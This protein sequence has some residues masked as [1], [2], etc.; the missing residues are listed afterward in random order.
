MSLFRSLPPGFV[1]ALALTACSVGGDPPP[2][3]GST[4]VDAGCVGGVTYCGRGEVVQRCEGGRRVDVETCTGDRVCAEGLGCVAC[5]P[6]YHECQGDSLYVCN[7][8]GSAFTLVQTCT[9]DEL[10]TSGGLGGA[11]MNACDAAVANRSNIGCEYWA[12]DLDNEHVEGLGAPTI[13]WSEQF[14]V[15]IANPS[16]VT[17]TVRV[18]VN[19]GAVGGAIA[20]REVFSG[21]VA[22]RD[23]LQIDLDQREVDGELSDAPDDR[24]TWVSSHAYRIQSNYPV[25]AYQFNPIIQSFSNDA[26]LLLP[27]SGLDSH[28]RVLGYPTS[29]PVDIGGP[30]GNI[31]GIPDHSFVTIIGTEPNTMVRVTAGGPIIGDTKGLGIG[32]AAAGEV[33]ERVIGRYDV[34]NL[35]SDGMTGDLTG[36]VVESSRPVAVFSGG[37]SAIAPVGNDAPPPPGGIPENRCCTEHLEEQVY[38]TTSWGR[39]FVVTRSPVR[40]RTWQEPDIY[41][42]M[43][44]R[45]AATITTNLPAPDDSFTLAPGEWREFYA[46]RSFVLR[47]DAPVSLEQI[48]VSQ[49]WVDDWKPDHGGDPSMILF[50]PYEQYRQSYVFLT[51][52]TFSA[53]YVVVSAPI[54]TMV[55][56]DGG[57][58][59]GDE[60]MILC[61]YE[62]AGEIDGVAYDAITCPVED[63]A[64]TIDASEPVGIM[65]YGYYSV[66]SY[67]YAGGSDLERIN[68][69]I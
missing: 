2:P 40:G 30:F 3:D 7:G 54:G 20:E 39:D 6:G 37:E 44:D 50:P 24:G 18:Y 48:L 42:I 36:T 56:L 43:A 59:R 31:Q 5:R 13:A 57:D 46:Q 58:I 23:V 38:P 8:D 60:F 33:I 63:G 22:P 17:A 61:T 21:S 26:S 49:G 11:C 28:Y 16:D 32:P 68:P 29:K 1:A 55:L 51:P 62:P 66:G 25:V 67:G 52:S 12:V 41:R 64:H 34:L 4:D 35:E 53:D 10:C 9:A 69:L 47:S 14:A 65:V 15:V 19:D 45:A 27:T